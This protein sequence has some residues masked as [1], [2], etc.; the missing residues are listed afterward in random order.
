MNQAACHP[1]RADETDNAQHETGYCRHDVTGGTD[2]KDEKHG[3]E[4][5]CR[6]Q[7]VCERRG[8]DVR[9]ESEKD[10]RDGRGVQD[11]REGSGS[12]SERERNA[13]EKDDHHA[14]DEQGERRVCVEERR[15]VRKRRRGG[16]VT[17]SP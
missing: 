11:E 16:V 1:D 5:V 2:E 14:P 3:Y 15:G 4:G 10:V 17:V 8:R 7:G 9:H 12:G 13:D 6:A